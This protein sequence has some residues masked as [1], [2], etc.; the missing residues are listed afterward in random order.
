MLRG[1]TEANLAR[2]TSS[3]EEK[4]LQ[5]LELESENLCLK[6][7][8]YCELKMFKIVIKVLP[9]DTIFNRQTLVGLLGPNQFVISMRVRKTFRRHG[10]RLVKVQFLVEVSYISCLL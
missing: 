1:E 4:V 5:C 9:A 8:Q 2:Y 10:L 6:I 7:C 3:V